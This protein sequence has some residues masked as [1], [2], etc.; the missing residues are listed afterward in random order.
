MILSHADKLYRF[1]FDDLPIR[2]QWVR[3]DQVLLEAFANYKYPEPV[4]TLLAAQF[5][6]VS[7]FADNLKFQGAVSL[8]SRGDGALVR[9]LTECRAQ[10]QLRGIAHINADLPEP[11]TEDIAQWLGKGHLALSLIDAKSNQTL[12]QGMIELL[13]SDLAAN[14][15]NYFQTS[16]Q[17]PTLLFFGQSSNQHSRQKSETVTGLLLQRLPEPSDATEIAIQSH[18]DAWQTAMTLA[19]TL[20]GDRASEL[21]TLAPQNLLERLFYEFPCRLHEPREL[22]Y[23]CTC[24]K[25]KSDRT[26][27]TLGEQ[28]LQDILAE[29]GQIH[30]DCEL[31]GARY[32]YDALDVATL[33]QAENS[34]HEPP[35]H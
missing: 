10:H 12:H 32:H 9:S 7:M 21:A 18:E 30:V 14:L 2:G 28:E 29:L 19:E 1:T 3:L 25:E 15:E 23:A 22:I 27:K 34:Q 33:A 17:L 16:E 5:A 13:Q 11:A 31:C 26:L 20:R 4:R 24:S 35:L 6:A 8:Q